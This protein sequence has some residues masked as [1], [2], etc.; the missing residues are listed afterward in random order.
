MNGVAVLNRIGEIF[1]EIVTFKQRPKGSE[2][3]P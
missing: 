1:P 3:Q 2:S